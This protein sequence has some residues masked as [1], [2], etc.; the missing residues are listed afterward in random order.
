MTFESVTDSVTSNSVT[1]WTGAH[2]APPSIEFFRQEYWSGLSFPTQGAISDLGI[3]P[4]SPC[5]AGKFF[6]VLR[7]QGSPSKDILVVPNKVK[8]FDPPYLCQPVNN[9]SKFEMLIEISMLI[10]NMCK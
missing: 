10:I 8:T 6:T 1:P 4:G 9:L 7:H 3:K 2:Q 5:I